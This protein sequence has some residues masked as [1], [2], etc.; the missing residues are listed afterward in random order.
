MCLGFVENFAQFVAVRALLG[1]AE[2]G[3]L[4][5]M[6]CSEYPCE[7]HEWALT[8]SGALSVY[9]L[10]TRRLSF[11]NWSVLYSCFS[12][13]CFW[14]YDCSFLC[15]FKSYTEYDRS[16]R[17]RSIRNRSPRGNRR[18]EMDFDHRRSTGESSI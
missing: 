14:R 9:F 4:P 17:S 15:Y 5:G 10:Q 18:L 3:L 8:I 6:V 1:I 7:L 12:I 2:G 16:S 13:G 11:A